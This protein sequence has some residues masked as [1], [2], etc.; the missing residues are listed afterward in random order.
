M[1]VTSKVTTEKHVVLA[2]GRSTEADDEGCSK[3]KLRTSSAHHEELSLEHARVKE[4]EMTL[5]TSEAE[6]KD[7]SARLV[8]T[9]ASS[10]DLQRHLSS[11]QQEKEEC[12][13][14]AG[15]LQRNL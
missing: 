3:Q 8:S 4:L 5:G 2:V 12:E 13:L 14:K 1:G 10:E 11:L 9:K 6:K 7:L 15:K